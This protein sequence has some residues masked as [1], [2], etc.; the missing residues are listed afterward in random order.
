MAVEA[1]VLRTAVKMLAERITKWSTDL[2]ITFNADS[3]SRLIKSGA[4]FE[5]PEGEKHEEVAVRIL[6]GLGHIEY[7]YWQNRRY[8]IVTPLG[9]IVRDF[10]KN[11]KTHEDAKLHALIISSLPFST[12]M[13][14]VYGLY[15]T[16]GISPGG[17]YA[18]IR[19]KIFRYDFD[20]KI[21]YY[22][23][24]ERLALEVLLEMVYTRGSSDVAVS[25]TEILATIIDAYAEQLGGKRN[26]NELFRA[27]NHR[28][29]FKH[30][31]RFEYEAAAWEALAPGSYLPLDKA[32]EKYGLT[33]LKPLIDRLD[34]KFTGIEYTLRCLYS[35]PPKL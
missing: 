21:P 16:H 35:L 12:K 17:F 19:D 1:D 30:K 11:P 28:L 25:E 3:I 22:G 9:D 24:V 26:L 2:C 33:A 34:S 10:I 7:F 31:D 23:G 29:R 14:V 20:R 6:R 15:Y 27:L 18:T 32:L 13:R 5:I 4:A 8:A